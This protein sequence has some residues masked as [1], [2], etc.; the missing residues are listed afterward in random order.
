LTR[1]LRCRRPKAGLAAALPSRLTTY[2]HEHYMRI[3]HL[4]E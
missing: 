3:E 4:N 1:R 2:L